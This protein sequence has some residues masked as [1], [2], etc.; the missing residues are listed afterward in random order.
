MNLF[1]GAEPFV[2]FGRRHHEE[3][4]C[5]IILNMDQWFNRK[6][7]SKIFLIWRTGRPLFDR[8]EP[9]AQL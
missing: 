5:E 9:F 1:C 8:A 7:L 6:C 3:R 2:H 4:F